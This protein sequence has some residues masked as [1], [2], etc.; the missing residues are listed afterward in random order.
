M[1]KNV[2]HS[3][4][5]TIQNCNIPWSRCSKTSLTWTG[6]PCHAGEHP[7]GGGRRLRLLLR[8]QRHRR[9]HHPWG[10]GAGSLS[11]QQTI[12]KHIFC[13]ALVCR[14]SS[15]KTRLERIQNIFVQGSKRYLS[16]FLSPN[17]EIAKPVPN[18]IFQSSIVC[19]CGKYLRDFLFLLKIFRVKF[20]FKLEYNVSKCYFEKV[21]FKITS[22]IKKL[23]SS[24]LR[25]TRNWTSRTWPSWRSPTAA[26]SMPSVS[27]SCLVSSTSRT[28]SPKF[29]AETSST[30]TLSWSGWWQSWSRWWDKS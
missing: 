26:P 3:V 5:E 25:S 27:K 1:R 18:K 23:F 11:R 8:G 29:T 24:P 30:T 20:K 2:S 13:K 21:L 12:S 6:E 16:L 17:Y 9:S 15:S 4:T 14:F 7:G 22:W 28:E 10:A 19:D